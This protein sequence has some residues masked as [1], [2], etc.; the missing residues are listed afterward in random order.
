MV[1]FCFVYA[2]ARLLRMLMHGEVDLRQTLRY[3]A[4]GRKIN[5]HNHQ[6]EGAPRGQSL[7]YSDLVSSHVEA[8]T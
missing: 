2:K 8:T 6:P 1:L 7:I 3:R 5:H 4:Y